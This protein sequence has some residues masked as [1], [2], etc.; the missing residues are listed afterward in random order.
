MNVSPLPYTYAMRIARITLV[1]LLVLLAARASAEGETAATE[2]APPPAQATPASAAELV[3]RLD[4]LSAR[5]MEIN[6][7]LR[8][9]APD[10]A[11]IAVALPGKSKEA[12]TVLGAAGTADASGAD[13]VEVQATLQKLR[14]LDRIFVKWRARMQDEIALLDPWRQQLRTDETFVREA[15]GP[16]AAGVAGAEA[17]PEALRGRLRD[18]ARNLE[19][20]QAP[21]R[22][23]L[24]VV[25]AADVQVGDLQSALR[26][27]QGQ[28]DSARLNRQQQAL[29]RTA[30]PLWKVPDSLTWP[31]AVVRQNLF[32][33]RAGVADYLEGHLPEL[34]AF[35]LV[36]VVL[37]V[38]VIQLRRSILVQGETEVD[39]LI[40]RYPFAITVLVWTLV[41]PFLLLPDMPLGLNLLRGLVDSLLLWRMLP[42]LV[43]P[44]EARPLKGL[45]FLAVALL[46]TISLLGNEWYGRLL[47]V[48]LG[49]GALLTFRALGRA[50]LE[51]ADS[52]P[53]LRRSIRFVASVAPAVVA[54]GLIAEVAGS[55]TLAQQAIGGIVFA[56]LALCTMVAADAILG[57]ILQAWVAGP[58]ARWFR[59]VNNWPDAVRVWGQRAI[60]IVLV[61]A[62]IN[63][64]P[65]I[66]PVLEPVWRGVGSLLTAPVT[67][68]TLDLSVGG[69]LWFL[70]SLAVA[71]GVARFVRFLL[72]EDVLPRMPLAMGAAS[73]ASR[74]IYYALVLLGIVFAL[75]ASGVELSKLTLVV[76]ALSV[77]VG[78]GLQTIV[79]NFVSGLILAFERPVR[80]GDQITLGTT[81]G[82]V[83]MIGLRA[84]RIR[85][86]EGAEV[87]VPNAN[88]ISSE[89]TNWTLSD[90]ARRLDVTVGVDYGS[91]PDRVQ[92]LLLE[93]V[94]DLSG[95]AARPAPMT[96]FRGFG[97]SSL[98]FSLLLWT[99]D[100]DDR[101]EV[102][103]NARTR[104]LNALRAAGVTIP[105]PQLDVH[106]RDG[107]G[108]GSTPAV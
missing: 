21:L 104:V 76:S 45:L 44:G 50:A 15:A 7:Y 24:D 48:A 92:V 38:A 55:R 83:E 86:P 19:S 28:L 102:E 43:N 41:G 42:A 30:P 35:G 59:S 17:V 107:D 39:H 87:I 97:A 93:A 13:M 32:G 89:V 64:L 6:D 18:L 49:L 65:T 8:K 82:R 47:T 16:G 61:V 66:L 12:Q 99:K 98:D 14:N 91:D 106:L 3:Q 36:L 75:A 70:A 90:R 54:I 34:T 71:L 10:L 69:V 108:T 63:L 20:T 52:R 31:G 105:F 37:L 85:T 1:A 73:A 5:L 29:E 2:P 80:E 68:G 22:K 58:G 72:D 51:G 74:L 56:S 81:I 27:L 103:S 95:V 40:T 62:F 26:D 57:S 11:G 9:P 60:R 23:R 84:T 100:I 33:L 78:F 4:A 77:G 96:V 79:N 67:F 101:L 25:V 53:L 94:K 46:V 88:F